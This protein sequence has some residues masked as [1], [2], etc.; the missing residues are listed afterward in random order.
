M[1][2][3]RVVFD[4]RN[5]FHS[6][7]PFIAD[8]HK[9]VI[10]LDR[11]SEIVLQEPGGRVVDLEAGWSQRITGGPVF[12]HLVIVKETTPLSA[13]VHDYTSHSVFRSA[14]CIG[15][16]SLNDPE[17]V[18]LWNFPARYDEAY[19]K[20][21]PSYELLEKWHK[22]VSKRLKK[23]GTIEEARDTAEDCER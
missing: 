4:V 23:Y 15:R 17:R 21:F 6:G 10:L 8:G 20:I 7:K 1:G 16:S 19:E 11:F 5:L 14:V 9:Y 13:G 18:E 22:T 3:A 12:L 2:S